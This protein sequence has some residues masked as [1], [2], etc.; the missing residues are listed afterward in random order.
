MKRLILIRHGQTTYSAEKRYCGIEDVPLNEVGKKQARCITR[1]FARQH[2]DAV[3][4]SDLKRCLET[5]FIAFPNEDIHK[6]RAMREID[7]GFLSGKRYDDINNV[8]PRIY[9]Q[10]LKNPISVKMPGGEA[11]SGFKRRIE[12]CFLRI[13]AQN[14]RKVV[15][16]VAHG[17]PIRIIINRVLGKGMNNFWEIRQDTA[18]VNIVDFKKG[19]P[20]IIKINDTSHLKGL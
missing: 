20:V 3:Y 2:I 9:D 7:F 6:R 8:Y 1:K 15:A 5:A 10:W 13:V 17:G 19:L 12:K 18:A 11:V 4:S 16:V 14:R